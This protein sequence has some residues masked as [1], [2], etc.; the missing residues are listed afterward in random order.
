M[1]FYGRV[2]DEKFERLAGWFQGE[3]LRLNPVGSVEL[4]VFEPCDDCE[5]IHILGRLELM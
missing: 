4:E 2:V 3:D 5:N 1:E